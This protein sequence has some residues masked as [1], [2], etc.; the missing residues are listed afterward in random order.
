MSVYKFFPNLVAIQ[1]LGLN[2][3]MSVRFSIYDGSVMSAEDRVIFSIAG[4]TNNLQFKGAM[5]AAMLHY[6]NVDHSYGMTIDDIIWDSIPDLATTTMPGLL[7]AS[8]KV[9]L[10]SLKRTEKYSGT[11]NSSGIYTVTFGTAF[12]A[13]P[14]IQANI[15]GA[16]DTQNLRITSISTTG[17]TVTVRNRTDVVGLLPTWSNVNG[18]NVD[19]LITEK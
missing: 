15:I 13:A 6:A 7:S 16:T 19:V 18:A 12:S 14:N 17:F 11:T 5:D 8:D 3:D 1:D 2:A 9:K 4:V 10:N